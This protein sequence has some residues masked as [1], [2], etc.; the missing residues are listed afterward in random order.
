[1]PAETKPRKKRKQQPAYPI[2]EEALQAF[3]KRKVEK[4][5]LLSRSLAD[6]LEFACRNTSA[7][8]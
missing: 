3:R 7:W 1:M 2:P 5:V 8:W 4:G 6:A